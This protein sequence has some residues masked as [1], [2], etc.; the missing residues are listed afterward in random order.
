MTTIAA[1]KTNLRIN[2]PHALVLRAWQIDRPEQSRC[3][4]SA[5]IA[6]EP[7]VPHATKKPENLVSAGI[8][9]AVPS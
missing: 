4:H 8:L 9:A 1:A 2:E 6:H 5:G 7:S 3:N